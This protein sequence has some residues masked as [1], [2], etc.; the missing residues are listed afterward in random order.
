[1]AFY[2]SDESLRD[3]LTA[4]LIARRDARNNPDRIVIPS[5]RSLREWFAYVRVNMRVR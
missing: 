2:F 4:L 1:M 5:K 3:E